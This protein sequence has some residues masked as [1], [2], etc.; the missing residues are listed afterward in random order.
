MGQVIHTNTDSFDRVIASGN[1]LVDFWAP[2]C[3]PCVALG[4]VLDSVADK[5]PNLCIAKVNVDDNSELASR[6]NIRGI[7]TMLL[8]RDGKLQA[9][10]VGAVTAAG[11]ESWLLEEGL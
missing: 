1:V 11:L 2:W 3:A 8:F 6:Y 9:T 5:M 4:P 7:P 10:K